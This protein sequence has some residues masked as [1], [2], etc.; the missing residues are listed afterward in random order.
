M[1]SRNTPLQLLAWTWLG[2][3]VGVSLIA[4]PAKFR[5]ESLELEVALDVGRTTFGLFSWLQWGLI[6]A[7]VSLIAGAHQQG[8]AD[9][10]HW[11]LVLGVGIILV[12]QSLWILPELN[13]RVAIVIAGDPL[14]GSPIHFIF[15]IF[16][17]TKIVLLGLLGLL[18]PRQANSHLQNLNVDRVPAEE[19]A[20]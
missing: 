4:T 18:I 19:S 3:V 13:D 12:A 10:R 14:P 16:E 9:Q 17:G 8:Q 5:A 6:I 2:M 7:L 15:A 1:T 20:T 11:L